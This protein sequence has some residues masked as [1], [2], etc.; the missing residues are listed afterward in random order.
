M[1]FADSVRCPECNEL[2]S[3]YDWQSHK[4]E[5][6]TRKQEQEIGSKQVNER[7]R[8][9][10]KTLKKV[11]AENVKEYDGEAGEILAIIKNYAA[12]LLEAR[13]KLDIA[14]KAL[15]SVVSYVHDN[16]PT[17]GKMSEIVEQALKEIQS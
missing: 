15:E 2:M 12:D 7:I 1:S 17:M 11:L 14:V 13:A 9:D 16:E 10:N 8:I 4:C 6:S 5:Q 3:E